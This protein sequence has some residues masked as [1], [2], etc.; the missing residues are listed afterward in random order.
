MNKSMWF[1]GVATACLSLAVVGCN[2][3][4]YPAC[5]TDGDCH[6]SEFCVQQQCQQ[7]RTDADCGA[8]NQCVAGRCDPIPNYCQSDTQCGEGM[9]CNQ[10]RCEAQPTSST[11][12][13]GTSTQ[14]PT[15]TLEPIY[16]AFDQSDLTQQSRDAL[17][18][19]ARA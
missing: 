9:R 7:C 2:K 18:A 11:Q 13:S 4:K 3:P 10:Q 5:K 8:G 16:F 14:A 19:D 1:L 12:P 17:A 15:C 6:Q